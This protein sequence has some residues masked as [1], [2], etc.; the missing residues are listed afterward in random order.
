[1]TGFIFEFRRGLEGQTLSSHMANRPGKRKSKCSFHT[2][3]ISSFFSG[4]FSGLVAFF[5]LGVDGLVVR[6]HKPMGFI[7]IKSEVLKNVFTNK[8]KVPMLIDPPVFNMLMGMCK[9]L[10]LDVF[11]CL[12]YCEIT[13]LILF[14]LIVNDKSLR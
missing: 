7:L 14:H 13:K 1:M 5:S 10:L 9:V 6:M 2:Q 12:T 11:M 8:D 3:D 4:E